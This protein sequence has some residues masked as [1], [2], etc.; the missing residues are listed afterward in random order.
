[1]VLDN[2][3][4]LAQILSELSRESC[5]AWLAIDNPDIRTFAGNEGYADNLG[6]TYLWDSTVPNHLI[7]KPRDVFVLWDSKQLLGL[8]V[9]SSIAAIA[10]QKTRFR[11]PTCNSTNLRKRLTKLPTYRCG[12]QTCRREF[13]VPLKETIFVTEYCADYTS[14]WVP[15]P[16][17]LS[18]A[19]CRDLGRSRKS[20]H[21]IRPAVK[22]RILEVIWSQ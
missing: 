2:N 3:P 11:C 12:E 17:R 16:G 19:N 1:M 22:D 14:C 13:A 5:N 8:S 21:S 7:V 9:V 6:K 10:S 18:A 4:K 15:M 20:Q